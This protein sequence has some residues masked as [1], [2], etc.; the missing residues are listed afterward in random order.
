MWLELETIRE[1]QPWELKHAKQIK[2]TLNFAS[3][4]HLIPLRSCLSMLQVS[5]KWLVVNGKNWPFIT[6]LT[7]VP[8]VTTLEILIAFILA[9]TICLEDENFLYYLL[10][11]N[12]EKMNTI[13]LKIFIHQCLMNMFDADTATNSVNSFF[14]FAYRCSYI[15]TMLYSSHYRYYTTVHR[16]SG[17]LLSDR[18]QTKLYLSEC[19]LQRKFLHCG[20]Y[21]LRI[22]PHSYQQWQV[23]NWD[24]KTLYIIVFIIRLLLKVSI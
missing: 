5:N 19:I 18:V 21:L 9:L 14:H 8:K 13:D 23:R 11:I 12:L 7:K 2:A 4:S 1:K 20:R 22:W 17:T 15:W 16:I 24:L 6:K 10:E 3:L